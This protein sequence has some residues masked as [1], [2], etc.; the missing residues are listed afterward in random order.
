MTVHNRDQILMYIMSA[1]NIVTISTT[2]LKSFTVN[3]SDRIDVR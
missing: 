1:L 2:F 3:L